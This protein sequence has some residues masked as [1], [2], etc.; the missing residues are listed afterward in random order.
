MRGRAPNTYWNE[1][2]TAGY[3]NQINADDLEKKTK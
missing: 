1:G 2:S 3:T